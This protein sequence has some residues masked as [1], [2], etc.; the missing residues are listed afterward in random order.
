MY[1]CRSTVTM[2]KSNQ[3][4]K[5]WVDADSCPVQQEIYN[6]CRKYEVTPVF[7][8]TV[9]HYSPEKAEQGWV[10]LDH[11][12]QAVDLY[13]LNHVTVSDYV[14]TQDLSLAVLLTTRGV[15]VLTPRGKLIKDADA[16]EIMNNK[17]LRQQTMKKNK[18]WKGPSAFKKED[19][20]Y[21]QH[22]FEK[23]LA[24]QEGIQ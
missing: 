9:N 12:S 18:K 1:Y 19:S 14:I 13:I 24:A 21:F 10:F 4:P 11:G 6:V 8:A 2:S 15:Y 5:I 23:L 3:I 17:Y 22:V 7:I 20:E 16:D